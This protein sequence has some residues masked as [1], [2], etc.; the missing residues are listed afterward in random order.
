MLQV[1]RDGTASAG[2]CTALRQ[3]VQ[4]DRK[5]AAMISLHRYFWLQAQRHVERVEKAIASVDSA[6]PLSP[7]DRE[8]LRKHPELEL[9]YDVSHEDLLEVEEIFPEILR[10]STFVFLISVL[11]T[12]LNSVC[13]ELQER[14]ASKFSVYDL[15]GRGIE[16]AVNYI[17]LLT[18]INPRELDGWKQVDDLRKLRNFFVHENGVIYARQT[19]SDVG[20]IAR[21]HPLIRLQRQEF[22]KASGG[23]VISLTAE[24]CADAVGTIDRFWV[25]LVEAL[26]KA[27]YGQAGSSGVV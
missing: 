23:Y 15:N 6:F 5:D 26:N 18:G 11:E 9:E 25:A 21:Q 16:R 19:D 7:E 20:R 2:S 3:S 27:I 4:S 12:M 1:C 8:I 13:E 22:G 24:F 10:R 14:Y 17:H